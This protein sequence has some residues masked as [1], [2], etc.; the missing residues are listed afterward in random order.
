M[1]PVAS[2]SKEFPIDAGIFNAASVTLGGSTDA[3]ADK[4]ILANTAFPD[5]DIQIG[6]ISVSADTGNVQVN[7][8]VLPAGTSVS[9]EISGSA[10]AGLGVFG[11][12]ADAIAALSLTDKLSLP[13]S[14][15]A[16]QR[17]LMLDFGYTAK[18]TAS[19][20]H[21]I[22]LLGSV[23]F[24]VNAASDST[25][26]LLHRFA[27]AQ[28]AHDVMADAFASWRLPRHI[29]FDG[30]DLNIKPQTWI[31]VEADGSLA[32]KM[33]ASLGWNM[34]FAKDLTVL[35]VTHN[36]SAKIDASLTANFGFNVSGNYIVVVG[37]ED[38]SN[39]VRLRLS[40]QSTKGL[41]FGL[42]L[43]VGVQGADPQLP[44]NFN[45][46]IEAT[47]G[48][49]GLQVL[50]DLQQWTDPSTDLGQK[51]AG[52]ADQTALD[53]LKSTTGIDPAAE[54]DKAKAIV[55][56]AL[57]QW[58]A[59]PDKLSS[60]LWTFLGK[61]VGAQPV[62]DFKTFLTDLANPATGASAL[63]GALEKATFGDTPE[64]QFLESI[65]DQGLLALANKLGAVSTAASQVLNILNG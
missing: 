56:N 10:Q 58:T 33:A 51:I 8:N 32:L 54:F 47:F 3:N 53:L 61:E 52:L 19:G 4:A 20:S 40:K 50:N 5:G 62:A 60:M 26:A 27:A 28:G 16:G 7:S 17:Y 43:N 45:D 31:L 64:G 13:I 22:G 57:N 41:N 14:D 48:V 9:F 30:H 12:F 25:Y 39:S 6:H 46:F 21:P 42:N 49:H 38:A 23:S 35:G 59:L 24:G 63:A 15:V 44:A 34:S 55:A 11:K 2:F 65:A 36:L 18:L 37:R 29:A 1:N